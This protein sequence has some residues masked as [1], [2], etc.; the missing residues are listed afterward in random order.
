VRSAV[1]DELLQGLPFETKCPAASFYELVKAMDFAYVAS[2]TATLE[3]ALIGTPFF[4]LYKASWSTYLLGKYLIKVPY[5]GLVN[6]LADDKVVPEFIQQDAHPE[7]LAHEARFFLQNP[8]LQEKMKEEF[9]QVRE[10][11]GEKGASGRAA[12]EVCHFLS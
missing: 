5:L 10:K 12:R 3:T 6:L 2:G 7:T 9:R 4:L 11:L 1:Y 8:E